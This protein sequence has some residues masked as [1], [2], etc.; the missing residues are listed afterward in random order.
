[1]EKIA[2][3]SHITRGEEVIKILE[4]LGGVNADLFRVGYHVSIA[5]A[6]NICAV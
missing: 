2:I 3:T 4:S 1:M 5:L 6:W